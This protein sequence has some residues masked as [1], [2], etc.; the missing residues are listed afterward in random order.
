MIAV[1]MCVCVT[2]FVRSV[3]VRIVLVCVGGCVW[4]CVVYQCVLYWCVWVCVCG[5]VKGGVGVG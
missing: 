3:P 4:V 5:C 1:Y 2:V